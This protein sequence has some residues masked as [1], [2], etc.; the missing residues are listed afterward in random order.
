MR[1]RL[2]LLLSTLGFFLPSVLSAQT[3]VADI[4]ER[5]VDKPLY[6]AGCW[7][8]D[9]LHFDPYGHL[10]GSSKLT[11]FTLCGVKV[12]KVNLEPNRLVVEGKR[13]G[14]EFEDSVPKRVDLEGIRITIDRPQDDDFDS[15]LSAI[16]AD[17]LETLV[18]L[19]P[20]YWQPFARVNILP[21]SDSNHSTL[22]AAFVDSSLP[23]IGGDVEPPKLLK[24]VEPRYSKAASDKKYLGSVLICLIIEENGIP[25]H[26]TVVRPA[27]L[28]LDEQALHAVSQ[29]VFIPAKKDGKPVRVQLNIEVNFA[30]R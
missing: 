3:T 4:K 21:P 7:I 24:S 25:S 16:F 30:Y 9:N 8:E 6:L 27:G 26:L 2:L 23:K 15:A 19:L 22:L 18:P 20:P 11:T 14:L 1:V 17:N 13:V 10:V 5:L 12:K 29:Y 28:A